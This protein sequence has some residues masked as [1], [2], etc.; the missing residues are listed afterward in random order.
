MDSLLGYT[1]KSPLLKQTKKKPNN[2]DCSTEDTEMT[3]KKLSN[4]KDKFELINRITKGV[5]RD[6]AANYEAFDYF[7]KREIIGA[8]IHNEVKA[9]LA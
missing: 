7:Q 1:S 2:W 3:G 5:V 6:V 8:S 9:E 4:S